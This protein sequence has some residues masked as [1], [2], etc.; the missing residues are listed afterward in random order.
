MLPRLSAGDTTGVR[1]AAHRVEA[2]D[3]DR[4]ARGGRVDHL[5][6]ADV[7]RHVAGRAVVEAQVARL[8][9]AP[10]HRSTHLRLALA[11]VRQADTG[12][13]VGVLREAGAVELVGTTG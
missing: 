6:V 12:R 4:L 5:A 9:V 1:E 3:P 11:G 13:G 10:R 7:H 2:D 8:Q